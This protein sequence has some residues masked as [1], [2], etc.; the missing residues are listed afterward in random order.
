MI[1]NSVRVPLSSYPPPPEP[2]PARAVYEP[3]VIRETGQKDCDSYPTL[4][5][6]LHFTR[7]LALCYCNAMHLARVCK[8]LIFAIF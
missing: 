7:A 5:L 2:L 4:T 6:F 3:R 1:I 8:F